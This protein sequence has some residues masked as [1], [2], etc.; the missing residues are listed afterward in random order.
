MTHGTGR[1]IVVGIDGSP[2]A[3]HAAQ[4]AAEQARRRRLPLRLV[5]AVNVSA[6]AYSG[7]IDPAGHFLEEL[8]SLGDQ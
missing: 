4:W 1:V 7:G 3:L 6:V 2:S 8:E 5:H